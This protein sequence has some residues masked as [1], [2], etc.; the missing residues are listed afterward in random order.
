MSIPVK[1]GIQCFQCLLDPTVKRMTKKL[2][3]PI[4]ISTFLERRVAHD[5]VL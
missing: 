3:G 1:N 2:Y 4:L 5:R